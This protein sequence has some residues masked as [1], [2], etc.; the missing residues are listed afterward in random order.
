VDGRSDVYSLGCVLHEMLA[1]TPP[2]TGATAEDVLR[3]HLE[4]EPPRLPGVDAALRRALAK[5][6]ADRF[7]TPLAFAEALERRRRGWRIA[8][9]AG[10]ALIAAVPMAARLIPPRFP[11]H[12]SAS[13][14]AVLPLVPATG[15]TVVTRLARDL[16]VTLSASLDGVGEIRTADALT[17]L[18]LTRENAAPLT[19]AQGL[20]LGRRLGASSVVMGSVAASGGQARVDLGLYTTDSAQVIARATAIAPAGDLTTLTD[21]LTWTLLRDVWRTRAPPTPSLAALTTRSLTALRAFLEGERAMLDGQWDGAAQAYGQAMAAD[22]TFWLAF[23]RYSYARW[24]YLEAVDDSVL[25]P[26]YAHRAALP[27]RDRLVLES[28]WTDTIPLAL[29]RGREAVTR[30]PEYWPGWMQ[31]ADWLFHAGPVYGHR[32]DEALAALERTVALNPSFLPAWEHLYWAAVPGDTVLAAR[33][34]EELVRLGFPRSS[35]LEFGFDVS[36][37]YRLELLLARSGVLDQIL[38]DSIA[39][40]LVTVARGRVGGGSSLLPVQVELSRRVLSSNPRPDLA[41]AHERLLADAWAGRG[42]WDS[43]LAVAE[44]YTRRTEGVDALAAYRLAVLG[45]WVGALPP[46][47][48]A[49]YRR[50]PV[51]GGDRPARAAMWW[52]EL[53]WLDGLLAVAR[54]DREEVRVAR[55]RVRQAGA[56]SS[57][58]LDRS[59]A[60]LE[61]E[62][63]DGRARAARALA[64]LN[65]DNPDVLVPGTDIHPYVIAVSRLAAGR[66]LTALGDTTAAERAFRWF[67]AAWALDGYRPA[68]RVLGALAERERARLYQGQ[69][70]A[71]QARRAYGEFL[72]RYDRPVSAHRSLV[73]E[74]RAALADNNIRR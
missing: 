38:I 15:D 68:R 10:L 58:V 62:L 17:V 72:R 48:A 61:A 57:V 66:W 56:P 54:R 3:R 34:L 7:A 41:A 64:T 4:S 67:D 2:F 25:T 36:R 59:L 23:W 45:A 63:D 6:P 37:V 24:W 74:A 39:R 26:L 33:A 20:Q 8:V 14:I 27:E 53:G 16:V 50:L 13:V 30:F 18:A 55:A 52:A 35:A 43:A 70:H 22:S 51:R 11:A 5:A 44:Q 1:G 31:Y 47:D 28:W 60:E 69:G 42:A 29:A 49:R 19:V 9:P 46:A 21:S 12:P 71:Q 65:W 40:D 32:A 73:E